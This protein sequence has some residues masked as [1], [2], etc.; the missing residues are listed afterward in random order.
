MG[1]ADVAEALISAGADLEAIGELAGA[2]P[3]HIAAK[4]NEPA[5]AAMLVEHGANVDAPD[6]QGR[7]PL[8]VAANNGNL[9]VAEA[10]LD[11]GA[12]PIARD[13]SYGAAPI[14]FAS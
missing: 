1:S 9:E 12:D 11:K 5:I 14:H 4:V 7:T 3:L 10:L 2:H 6:S 13:S 8:M